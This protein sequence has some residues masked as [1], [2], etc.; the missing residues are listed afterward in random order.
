M[1]NYRVSNVRFGHLTDMIQCWI[2]RDQ[3]FLGL[4]RYVISVLLW[5]TF[6]EI[7][8]FAF[9]ISACQFKDFHPV[10]TAV[11][12]EDIQVKLALKLIEWECLFTDGVTE[13][14]VAELYE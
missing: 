12:H 6:S 2:V 4:R 7:F 1:G 8:S 14:L 3:P 10:R 11:P 13:R 9:N 5:L